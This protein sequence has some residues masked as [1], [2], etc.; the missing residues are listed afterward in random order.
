LP[1]SVEDL[2]A[3]HALSKRWGERQVLD[4]TELIVEAGSAVHLSG[5][6]GV[7]KTTLLRIASGLIAPDSGLVVLDGMHPAR[8][9]RDYA[10]AIGFLTA[11]DR[12]LIARL[13][14]RQ[15]LTLWARMALLPPAEIPGAV[16]AVSERF[17]LAEMLNNRLDRSSLG[18]RQR[19]RLALTFLHRPRVVLLD[20]PANSLD[21]EGVEQLNSAVDEVLSRGGAAL[22]CS[23]GQD[24]RLRSF[25]ACYRLENGKILE[26]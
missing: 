11:G 15:T 25:T 16:A 20:E 5:R 6:N 13:K 18:Q 23:P 17:G 1:N 4:E 22:W 3:M 9:R 12:G 8:D 2:L 10:A 19:V 14:V 21:E 7:G 26:T 24:E